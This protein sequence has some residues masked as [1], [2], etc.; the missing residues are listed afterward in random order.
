MLKFLKLQSDTFTGKNKNFECE[1][2]YVRK[3]HEESKIFYT[4]KAFIE[5]IEYISW[6][7]IKERMP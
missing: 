1:V 2:S 5:Y 3:I 7:S 6:S 4:L